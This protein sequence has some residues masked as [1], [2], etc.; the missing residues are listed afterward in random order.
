MALLFD[1]MFLGDD[2]PYNAG[3]EISYKA[4]LSFA[5][6][7]SSSLDSFM[8]HVNLKLDLRLGLKPVF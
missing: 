1:C 5:A 4:C 6:S 8:G 2:L 3:S 7:T